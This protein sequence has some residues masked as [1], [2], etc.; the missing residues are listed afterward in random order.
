[1]KYSTQAEVHFNFKL[2]QNDFTTAVS[3]QLNR[4]SVSFIVVTKKILSD[5]NNRINTHD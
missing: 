3:K 4:F 5:V 1:M 2:F